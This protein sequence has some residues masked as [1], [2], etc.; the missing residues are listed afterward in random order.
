MKRKVL[1]TI[2]RLLAGVLL[3]TCLPLQ[4]FA[5]NSSP[6]TA[7]VTNGRLVF[8]G[9]FDVT[10]YSGEH[11]A[12]N[13]GGIASTLTGTIIYEGLSQIEGA[14]FYKPN[15]YN[16]IYLSNYC[17]F[18]EY[19]GDMFKW[20]PVS[21]DYTGFSIALTQ[22]SQSRY[23]LNTIELRHNGSFND[24]YVLE[25]TG[26][27]SGTL[28][29]GTEVEFDLD[30]FNVWTSNA[31]TSH[32]DMLIPLKGGHFS[33]TNLTHPETDSDEPEPGTPEYF[34]AEYNESTETATENIKELA[35]TVTSPT[36]VEFKG[37]DALPQNIMTEVKSSDKITL[38]FPFTYEGVNY[39]CKVTPAKAKLYVKDDIPW[40]GPLYLM[41]YFDVTRE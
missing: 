36:V 32:D 28:E 10:V 39:R 13:E 9:T 19:N 35:K 34:I 14:E 16:D 37:G 23:D 4:S 40:Y 6:D 30:D 24:G 29:D 25:V 38:E 22:D 17:F 7:V 5:T 18:S 31:V 26:H 20:G 33:G 8:N 2:G 41:Q 27:V 12:P 15:N 3:L 11:D 21:T 1:S